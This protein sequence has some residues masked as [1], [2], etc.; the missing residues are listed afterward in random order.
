MQTVNS[1]ARV[2]VPD[3]LPSTLRSLLD[4]QLR[5]YSL[6]TVIAALEEL[7]PAPPAE[8]KQARPTNSI[9]WLG[10]LSQWRNELRNGAGGQ[11]ADSPST[12]HYDDLWRS[13]CYE[14]SARELAGMGLDTAARH[15]HDRAVKSLIHE[16]SAA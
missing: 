12:W 11:R 16:K 6:D 1:H 7:R 13:A 9:R 4:E 3:G 2:L 5:T 10:S 15:E 8:T 14:A